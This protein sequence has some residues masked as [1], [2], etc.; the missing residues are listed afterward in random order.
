LGK[1]DK[2][3]KVA[4]LYGGRS[5]ERE[6]SLKSGAAIHAALISAGVDAYLVDVAADI[7]AVL[8]RENFDRAF[9]A[10]HG[11]EGEDGTMQG[12][13][14]W[15]NIPYT[16]SGILAS[17]LCM[18]KARAKLVW[19][20]AG[21]PTPNFLLWDEHLT[22]SDISKVLQFPLAVKPASEG[23]SIATFKVKTADELMPAIEK[24]KQYGEVVIEE[25]VIGKE[26]S[27]PVVAG[28]VLP[29]ICIETPREFYDYQA[30]YFEN[31]TQYH[32]PSG[33]SAEKEQ[34]LQALAWE[35]YKMLGCSGWGRVD[36]MQN[37]AGDF[38]LIEIN[39]VPGMT[40]S[41]LVPKGAVQF[42]WDF[43]TVLQKILEMTL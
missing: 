16:G 3:G 2:F 1:Q 36:V 12:L 41:S 25:W 23:S 43:P 19:L 33:L 26:F 17:A 4:V 32:C 11:P 7:V 29:S 35:S 21:L 30:K 8:E 15:M 22:V 37:E 13:L 24:A 28:Q 39:T 34:Q 6:I 42:G 40:A 27:V 38:Y 20:G 9:I 18:N 31:T 10:L 5:A 14:Q